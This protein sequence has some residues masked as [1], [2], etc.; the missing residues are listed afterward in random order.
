MENSLRPPFGS[1]WFFLHR[2]YG[3]HSGCEARNFGCDPRSALRSRPN[4][5]PQRPSRADASRMGGGTVGSCQGICGLPCEGQCLSNYGQHSLLVLL[6]KK[7]TPKQPSR[8]G[9]KG[10]HHMNDRPLLG[11]KPD[12]CNVDVQHSVSSA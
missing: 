6:L 2:K 8:Y 9:V 10:L 4:P 1:Q 7:Q 11:A 5:V 12:E 3:E